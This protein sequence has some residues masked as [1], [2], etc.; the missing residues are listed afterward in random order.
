[1]SHKKEQ[2]STGGLDI[3]TP[4]AEI[5]EAV[6]KQLFELAGIL[7][8]LAFNKGLAWYQETKKGVYTNHPLRPKQLHSTKT[9]FELFASGRSINRKRPFFFKE[10][11]TERHTAIIGSTGSGKSVCMNHLMIRALVN[12]F[13][14]ICFDPKPSCESV[15]QFKQMCA[16]FGRKAYVVSELLHPS[17]VFNPLVE[18]SA[19]EV[20]N[21]IMG[22]LEWSDS[23]YKNESQR[24]LFEAVMQLEREQAGVTI[25]NLVTKLTSYHD[26]KSISGLYTQLVALANS[27]YNSFMNAGARESLSFRKIRMEKSCLYVG[28]SSLGIGSIGLAVNK[29][30]FGNLFYHSKEAYN[31]VIPGLENPL[32]AP[33]AVFFD[34]L[35]STVNTSFIDLQNKCRA[36]GIQLTYATQCPSDLDRVSPEFTRQVFE[37]THNFFI[38]NQLVPAHTEFFANLAGT[39]T[40]LK[41]T[42]AM[43]DD[44]RSNFGTEREVEEFIAH[45]NIFRGLKVGQCI[46]IQ[47]M[48]KRVDLINVR[49]RLEFKKCIE[50]I[51]NIATTESIF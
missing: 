29:L 13:P 14:I 18:G 51:A 7:L 43:E 34:E 47:R 15:E 32:E 2:Q 4:F 1:M 19:H 39:T 26:R 21:R 50:H 46:F 10:L 20:T 16:H 40:T 24:A 28:I 42:Y 31:G 23:Y 6:F 11:N 25:S 45:A 36:S 41:K 17:D 3:V 5:L 27:E 38:F 35:S 49:P 22:A 9:S 48:P 44:K 37:N 33:I 30:F 8:K 12:N